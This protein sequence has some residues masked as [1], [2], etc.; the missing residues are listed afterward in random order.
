VAVLTSDACGETVDAMVN[1]G[2]RPAFLVG[3]ELGGSA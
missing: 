2:M 3:R 1:V